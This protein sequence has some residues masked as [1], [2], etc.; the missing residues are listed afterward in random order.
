[1]LTDN[2]E[3]V[4]DSKFTRIDHV[5]VTV[6]DLEIA[7]R[8]YSGVL[9]FKEMVCPLQDGHRIWYCIGGQQLHVNL[10][11]EYHKAGFGH[12]AVSVLH[13]EY[14]AYAKQVS[15][16][17]SISCESQEFADGV[18]RFFIHFILFTSRTYCKPRLAHITLS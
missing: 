4:M 2:K 18:Y 13:D 14:H 9:G 3:L 8:F 15:E 5:M 7:K 11:A 16:R 1:M 17:A 6:G 12:F 10:Q